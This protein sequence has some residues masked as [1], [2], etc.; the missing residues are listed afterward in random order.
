MH[1]LAYLIPFDH[2]ACPMVAEYRVGGVIHIPVAVVANGVYHRLLVGTGAVAVQGAEQPPLTSGVGGHLQGVVPGLGDGSG[3]GEDG[4]VPHS[5]GQL[6]AASHSLYIRHSS[7]HL[8]LR[9]LQPQLVPG[10]QKHTLGHFQSLTHGPV[11]GLAEVASLGVLGVGPPGEQGD[12]QISDGGSGEYAPVLLF[13]QVGQN[14]PLPVPVQHV[15]AAGSVK[16][17]TTAPRG[18]LQ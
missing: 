4:L 6:Q 11:G 10:L 17:Q 2:K 7:S 5:L 8:L 14:E 16:L 13:H 18:G 1:V 9:Q 15:L 12:A 3:A